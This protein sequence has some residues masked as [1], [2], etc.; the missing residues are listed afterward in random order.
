MAEVAAE[1]DRD[2]EEAEAKMVS[3]SARPRVAVGV[4]VPVPVAWGFAVGVGTLVKRALMLSGAEVDADGCSL[5]KR[6]SSEGEA[7]GAGAW[8]GVLCIPASEISMR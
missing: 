2:E 7:T 6:A 5:E 3:R 8:G 1:V 4:P